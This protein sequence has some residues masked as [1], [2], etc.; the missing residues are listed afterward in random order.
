M[1]NERSTSENL[2]GAGWMTLG[3][4]G[5]VVNDAFIKLAAESLPLFESIFIRGCFITVWMLGLASARGEL[6]GAREHLDR[7]L[8]LRV[9][10]ESIGTALYLSALTRVPLA[11]LTAVLQIVPLIVTFAAARLL[12]ERVNWRRVASV[13]AGFVGVMVII[14]PA[15]DD[16]NP[17]FLVGFL[18]V[19]AIVVR[20]IA[21]TSISSKIPSV[22]V[23]L[24]T[25]VT[26]TMMGL[27]GSLIEGWEVPGTRELLLLLAASVFLAVG[28]MAS[29]IT[30]RVG[31]MSFSAPF[32]YTIL[33]F[34]IALQIVVFN[35]VPDALTFVGAG[36]IAAA[37]LF[38]LRT[39]SPHT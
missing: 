29:V 25:A 38:S 26:I 24:T 33:V 37:G 36:I 27:L 39:Q 20:E 16:F 15:S 19:I 10:M 14:R 2:R 6:R 28:Y 3:M 4:A 23:S 18:V 30:I 9:L 8:G 17:W 21:T 11:G 32:R 35:D 13:L 1:N 31:D 5:Y 34:A 7:S 12:R 22:I